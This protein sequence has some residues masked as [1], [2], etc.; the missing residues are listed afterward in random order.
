MPASKPRSNRG[1]A[2]A[3]ENRRAIITAARQL[4]TERGLHVPLSAIARQAGVGQGVFYR[5][6]P[7]RLALALTVF[8]DNFAELESI[9]ADAD[10]TTFAQLWHRLVEMTIESAAFMEMVIAARR[11]L[12]DYDGPERIRN[13]I[14]APL[15][16]AQQA[17]LLRPDLSVQDVLLAERMVYGAVI[18]A[19]DAGDVRPTVERAL[20]LIDLPIPAESDTGQP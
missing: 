10:V 14:A 1:P 18:S 5:H 19:P 16:L 17:G 7:T 9:A 12:P 8:E 4:F 3:A 2:A 20:A 6:F 13:I 11:S 15:H